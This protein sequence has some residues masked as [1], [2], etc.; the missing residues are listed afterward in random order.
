MRNRGF[1]LIELAIVLVLVGVL[2][3]IG[4][5]ILG[6]LIKRIHYNQ[7]RERLEANVEAL[8]GY[9]LTHHGR[10]PSSD[11]CKSYL[12]NRKDAWG[13]DFVCVIASELV[14]YGACALRTTSLNATDESD[15]ATH[16]NLAFVLISGGPNL[17]IQTNNSTIKIYLPGDSVDDYPGDINRPEPYDD[18]VRYVSLNELQGKLSCEHSEQRLR[19]LNNE[20][21]VG[22]ENSDYTANIYAAGGVPFSGGGH[23]KW[24]YNATSLAGINILCNGNV[25]SPCV[26]P[27]SS[28][29]QCD[30]LVLN[31]TATSYGSFR[32]KFYVCDSE[33]NTDEKTLSLT[34]YRNSIY[35]NNGIPITVINMTSRTLY[36]NCAC[37]LSCRWPVRGQRLI[38]P[39]EVVAANQGVFFSCNVYAIISYE[40]AVQKDV[41][42]D[43]TVCFYSNGTITDNINPNNRCP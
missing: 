19:I 27:C 39:G 11:Q 20:L 37:S 14:T 21:P 10:L 23:Y 41:N 25:L 34:I 6:L 38:Y 1:T 40:I 12:R 26:D 36:W 24:C 13:K 29:Y 30:N 15:N 35:S 16:E 18:M 2:A 17:N 5:G 33:N 31:G 9:A 43:T 7:N 4:A 32:V 42:N 22:F 28:Y 8:I 3:G